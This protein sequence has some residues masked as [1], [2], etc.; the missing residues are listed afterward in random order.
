MRGTLY[1]WHP[2]TR[3]SM[4]SFQSSH[5]F[6]QDFNVWMS[7][8][9]NTLWRK[10]S[11]FHEKRLFISSFIVLDWRRKRG[12]NRL[13]GNKTK[14]ELNQRVS[15]MCDVMLS[16]SSLSTIPRR[17]RKLSVVLW[18]R[19]PLPGVWGEEAASDDDKEVRSSDEADATDVTAEYEQI[20][21]NI[22]QTQ[23][24]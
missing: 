6:L 23:M 17:H 20:V 12:G 4:K 24:R 18:L 19:L 1:F 14:T 21:N 9:K 8:L 11:R 15:V 2:Q 3:V 10:K 22:L 16:P 13:W 7:R 5:T